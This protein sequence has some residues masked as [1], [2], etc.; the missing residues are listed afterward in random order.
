[1]MT[2]SR[3]NICDGDEYAIDVIPCDVHRDMH[4]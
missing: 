1:M 4:S 3:K 2:A